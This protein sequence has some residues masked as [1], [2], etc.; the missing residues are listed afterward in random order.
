M[1]SK[2]IKVIANA[3]E[4]IKLLAEAGPLSPSD[5]SERTGIPRSSVYR[6]A[7]GLNV[8]RLTE[9]LPDLRFRLSI[10][11]LHLADSARAAM[12]EWAKARP[13]LDRLEERTGQTAF[14]SVPTHD[15][16]VCIDWSPGRG[17]GILILKPGRI[18]PLHAG[19]AGR[20]ILAYGDHPEGNLQRAPFPRLTPDTLTTAEQLREDIQTTRR[21]GY[22]LSDQDVTIGIGAVGVPVFNREGAFAGCVSLGGLIDEILAQKDDYVAVLKD[23]ALALTY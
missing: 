8:I 20:V 23:A 4:V 5:I 13:V 22:A 3:F 12:S 14:L 15:A 17:T 7:D 1:N 21:S 6:L 18:L 2:P 19:A 10:R 16:A 9:T 11:W